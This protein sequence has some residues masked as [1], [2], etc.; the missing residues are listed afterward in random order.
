MDYHIDW[1]FAALHCQMLSVFDKSMR[2]W[3]AENNGVMS[4]NIQDI[5][6]IIC[7]RDRIFL[8]E[9]KAF[10]TWDPKQLQKK[11]ARLGHLTDSKDGTVEIWP[12]LGTLRFFFV[13]MSPE[14]PTQID[15]DLW[16]EWMRSGFNPYWIE[17][18]TTVRGKRMLSVGRTDERGEPS[19]TGT[20]FRINGEE[21]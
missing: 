15:A 2:T 13:L 3:P 10:E 6:L 14:P 4:H 12:G 19:G 8:I 11:V 20:Y 21:A 9:A 16:P 5:D 7:D 18:K 17:L 1:I